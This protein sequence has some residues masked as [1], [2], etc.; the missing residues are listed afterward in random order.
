[1]SRPK[2]LMI[3]RPELEKSSGHGVRKFPGSGARL[4]LFCGGAAEASSALHSARP[5]ESQGV[6]WASL[7]LSL[8]PSEDQPN[9]AKN[10]GWVGG[11][12]MVETV[13]DSLLCYMV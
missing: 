8:R 4:R 6:L 3:L 1:M 2:H 11:L 7:N 5:R 13:N 9:P 10:H 12:H